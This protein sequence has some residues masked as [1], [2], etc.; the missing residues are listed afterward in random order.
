MATFD[1]LS[2]LDTASDLIAQFGRPASLRRKVTGGTAT[3]ACVVVEV[4]YTPTERNGSAIQ[5]TDRRFLLDPKST[6]QDPDAEEDYLLL[7]GEALRIVTAKR[8]Q[9]A[10]VNVL[11]D[12]Q[13]RR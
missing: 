8:T 3:R 7:D 12:L 11:W 9:P 1:Y 6:S 4:D 13:V 10:D 2:L 5:F